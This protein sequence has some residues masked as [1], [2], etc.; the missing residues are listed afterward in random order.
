MRL[1]RRNTESAFRTREERE[2]LLHLVHRQILEIN[3]MSAISL[4]VHSAEFHDVG[5]LDTPK[6]DIHAAVSD[7]WLA[8]K[9]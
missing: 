6:N 2:T 7:R 8:G 3:E 9:H 1:E 5:G 4:R